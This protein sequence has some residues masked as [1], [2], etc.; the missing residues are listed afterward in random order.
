MWK[1]IIAVA[2]VALPAPAIAF[3]GNQLVAHCVQSSNSPRRLLC[4]AYIRGII[5]AY[6]STS[7]VC[8]PKGASYREAIAIATEHL[9]QNPTERHRNASTIILTSVVEGG[10]RCKQNR[11]RVEPNIAIKNAPAS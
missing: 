7:H 5:D 4:S 9:R 8:P 6:I 10:W 1:L 2:F 3:N 11:R